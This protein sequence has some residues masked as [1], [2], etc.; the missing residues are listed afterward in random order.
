[1]SGAG[2][3]L[4]ASGEPLFPDRALPAG[5][6]LGRVLSTFTSTVEEAVRTALAPGPTEDERF[7]R[8]AQGAQRLAGRLLEL[9]GLHLAVTG[10][11]PSRPSVLVCNH[12]GYWDPVLLGAVL[13]LA[14]IAKSE[15]ASWPVL[16]RCGRALGTLYV[17]RGDANDGARVLRLA[18]RRLLGGVHLLN[19]PEGTT[20]NGEGVL[21]F[22][23]GVFG[24]AARASVP[25]VPVALR[26]WPAD[27]AWLGGEPFLPHYRRHWQRG[28][29]VEARVRF[30]RPLNPRDFSGARACAAEARAQVETLLGRTPA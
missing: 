15:L 30:G 17:R 9:N 13:P 3:T 25:V 14:A 6:V 2:R 10:L 22:R 29:V 12:L 21:P 23:R 11:L 28:G 27:A 16:G 20:T 19:F 26:L 18:L 7:R 4:A 8:Q 24:I 5:E 1:M